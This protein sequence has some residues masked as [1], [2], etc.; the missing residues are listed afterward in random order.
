MRPTIT[1]AALAAVCAPAFAQ[2]PFL[3]LE[4]HM[5]VPD[6][7]DADL[8]HAF[9]FTIVMDT[10]VAPTFAAANEYEFG[11]S[12]VSAE[13]YSFDNVPL[14]RSPF[15]PT[16]R[17]TDLD[18]LAMSTYAPESTTL[19]YYPTGSPSG[20]ILTIRFGFPDGFPVFD[21]DAL[22]I[23]NP[24]GFPAAP[25]SLPT[26]PAAY[27]AAEFGPL[28][29]FNGLYKNV[30]AN[31]D[32][33]VGI[34]WQLFEFLA[35]NDLLVFPEGATLRYFVREV[36]DPNAPAPCVA[37]CDANGTLNID[38]IDCFVSAFLGGCP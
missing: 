12:V 31:T 3:Q 29:G 34:S 24:A 30:S 2:G 15:R 14:D 38:D 7:I 36:E 5:T 37:D 10:S 9:G 8:E 25:T 28:V 17:P 16:D 27:E 4:A 18:T 13:I 32:R 6:P 19:F 23:D 35:P 1:A 20:S 11:N 22:T 21:F 26:D 33:S